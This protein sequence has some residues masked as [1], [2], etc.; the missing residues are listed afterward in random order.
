MDRPQPGSGGVA[1]RFINRFV[2]PPP[3]TGR[4]RRFSDWYP[5][6]RADH[7]NHVGVGLNAT[8][9]LV[10]QG[11][12]V[13]TANRSPQRAAA[14]ADA[15]DLPKE[16]LQHVL[17]DLGDLESVR[18]AVAALPES[19]DACVNAGLQTEAEAARAFA[20]GL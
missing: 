3:V 15:L 2:E 1:L 14:A 18:N 9:A 10:D 13:I 6:H 17:M 11:W 20:P 8:K 7:R 5:W 4:L 19:I 12:T 16:R